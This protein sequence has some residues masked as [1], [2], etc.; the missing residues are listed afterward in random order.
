VP[1]EEKDEKGVARRVHL[2]PP[3]TVCYED[4]AFGLLPEAAL[5]R[6]S[7]LSLR[8]EGGARLGAAFRA[9]PATLTLDLTALPGAA[10]AKAVTGYR[11]HS[12]SWTSPMK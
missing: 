2:G 11:C 5:R 4:G 6:Y 1:A 10:K 8:G 3:A 7:G 12:P 9:E